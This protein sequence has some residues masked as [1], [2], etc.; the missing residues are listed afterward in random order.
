MNA[1]IVHGRCWILNWIEGEGETL[2]VDLNSIFIF[3]GLNQHH[4]DRMH[5]N[6]HTEILK[7]RRVAAVRKNDTVYAIHMTH[8]QSHERIN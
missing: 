3:N 4:R 1:R 8:E 5:V 6:E 2:T 7:R